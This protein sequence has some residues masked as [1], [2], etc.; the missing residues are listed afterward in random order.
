MGGRR[1]RS[2]RSLPF[3]RI[4]AL[5]PTVT[6]W[7]LSRGLGGQPGCGSSEATGHRCLAR[8][9]PRCSWQPAAPVGR[10][11]WRVSVL[12]S[13]QSG[14]QI[15][16]CNMSGRPEPGNRAEETARKKPSW[17]MKQQTEQWPSARQMED[18]FS[19]TE[20]MTGFLSFSIL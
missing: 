4:Q 17:M 9:R 6:F 18:P 16:V 11:L 5:L 10:G 13:Q 19:P 15:A 3:H 1:Q 12:A 2:P 7:S 8:L 20:L 14:R